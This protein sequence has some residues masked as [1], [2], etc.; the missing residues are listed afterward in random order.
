VDRQD[1]SRTEGRTDTRSATRA[2]DIEGGDDELD[3]AILKV[4]MGADVEFEREDLNEVD[5][6]R[7]RRRLP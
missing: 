7:G 4:L 6:C 1:L 5:I 3:D 2:G